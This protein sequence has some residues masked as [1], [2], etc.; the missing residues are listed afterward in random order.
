MDSPFGQGNLHATFASDG[1]VGGSGTWSITTT[2]PKLALEKRGITAPV[3]LFLG[4]PVYTLFY[5]DYLRYWNK[6]HT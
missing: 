2:P 5:S 1:G 6:E 3:S 4:K